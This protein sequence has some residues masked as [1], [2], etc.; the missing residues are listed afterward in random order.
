VAF[1]LPVAAHAASGDADLARELTNPVADLITVPIQMNL[2]RGV[3]PTD[4]GAKV[5]INITQAPRDFG[6]GGR[7]TSC[8]PSSLKV[9]V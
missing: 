2:D 3:G 1:V 5:A 6:S 4:S 8:C 7:R 9:S